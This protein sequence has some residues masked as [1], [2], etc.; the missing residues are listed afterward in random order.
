M[1]S[2][3]LDK[4]EKSDTKLQDGD[5]VLCVAATIYKAVPYKQFVRPWNQMLRK[6]EAKAFHATDFYNGCGEFER[7]RS[8]RESLFQK[9][10]RRIPALIGRHVHRVVVTAFRPKEFAERASP[11]WRKNFG[12][13][14]HSIAVQ[15][16]LFNLGFWRRREC[17]SQEF[18]CFYESGD[19]GEADVA[20]AVRRLK[21]MPAIADILRVTSFDPIDKGRARGLEASDFVA[22]HWNK[23]FLDR[24]KLGD[25]TL[26][27]DFAAFIKSTENRVTHGLVSGEKL[28]EFFRTCEPLWKDIGVSVHANRRRQLP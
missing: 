17:P 11:Y 26:R 12:I 25:K 10:S 22:W 13:E 9:D 4:G 27:K 2:V 8:G 18:K 21:A 1:L 6:W 20:M 24:V 28:T 7:R 16:L 23:H 19:I 15:L 14:T 3:Y 5:A